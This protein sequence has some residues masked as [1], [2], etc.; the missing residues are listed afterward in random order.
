MKRLLVLIVAALV[1]GLVGGSIAFAQEDEV[2]TDDVEAAFV[3]LTR[4]EVEAMGYVVEE[5]CIT[6]EAV[7]AP[8]ELG[9][10][11]FH[12]VNESLIDDSIV[13]S[14]PEAVL[15]DADDNVIAVEYIGDPNSGLSVFGEDLVFVEPIGHDALH[16]W[17]LENLWFLQFNLWF[18]EN[19]LRFLKINFLQL[20]FYLQL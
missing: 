9:A 17:F 5:E 3:D 15:F 8:P 4:A 19:N 2:T 6:A 11:G 1:V 10:M 14:E 12:A 13:P 20:T 7:G 18:L 16:L